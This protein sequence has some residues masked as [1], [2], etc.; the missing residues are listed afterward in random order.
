MVYQKIKVKKLTINGAEGGAGAKK[1][2]NYLLLLNYELLAM[3]TCFP[4]PWRL[5]QKMLKQ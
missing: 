4:R 1:R 2:A 3:F 5:D